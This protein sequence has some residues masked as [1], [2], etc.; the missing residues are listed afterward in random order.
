MESDETPPGGP[1][2]PATRGVSPVLY[3]ASWA[4]SVDV[5]AGPFRSAGE[6]GPVRSE[7]SPQPN[8]DNSALGVCISVRGGSFCAP[9]PSA[10]EDVFRLGVWRGMREE[11]LVERARRPPWA[12]SEPSV[13]R[14]GPTPGRKDCS[15]GLGS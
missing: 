6:R 10:P 7:S 4:K 3:W 9:P 12:E 2:A 11:G 14:G 8:D 15:K 13:A 5:P 1:P